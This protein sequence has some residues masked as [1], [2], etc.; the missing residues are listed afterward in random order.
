MALQELDRHDHWPMRI[1]VAGLVTIG[2]ASVA[3]IAFL[4]DS[5]ADIQ[6]LFAIPAAVIA[7]LSMTLNQRPPWTYQRK[8][9][10]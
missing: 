2:I 5:G 7:A 3:A 8:K 10:D 9:D 4:L 6:G 1:A